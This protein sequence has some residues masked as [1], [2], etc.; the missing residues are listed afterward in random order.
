MPTVL[1]HVSEPRNLSCAIKGGWPLPSISPLFLG[2]FTWYCQRYIR[3]HFHS[4]RLSQSGRPP[5]V[6]SWPLVIYTNHAS[7]WDPLVGLALKKEFFSERSLFAPMDA[8]MLARYRMFSKLGFF[9]VEQGNPRGA[10][11]FLRA[12][13][14]ILQ[15]PQHLLAITAQGRFADARERPVRFQPGLGHLAARVQR[16]IFLPMA[17]EFVFWEERLPEILVRFGEAVEVQRCG[18]TPLTHDEWTGLF[19]LKLAAAQDALSLEAQRRNVSDFKTLLCGGSGQGGV[20]D[21]WRAL[22]AT[23]RGETFSK[24][25]GNK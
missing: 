15:S 8:A 13:E 3:R 23:I 18:A 6:A 21:L 7:W 24:E 10:A 1:T 25:H 22:K 14:A 16:A 12:S 17:T 5:D 4:L 19:A 11:Q 2:A 20:Y 9:G